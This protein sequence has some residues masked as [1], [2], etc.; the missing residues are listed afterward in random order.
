M[1]VFLKQHIQHHCSKLA[2]VGYNSHTLKGTRR[3]ME[4]REVPLRD[5]SHNVKFMLA[6]TQDVTERRQ[7]ELTLQTHREKL[8]HGSRVNM[9]GELAS[10]IAHELNQPLAAA[11]NFAFAL[12]ATAISDD[13][14]PELLAE[15][16]DAGSH[17]A[18][19]QLVERYAALVHKTC[20]R[21]VD[22]HILACR[23]STAMH[24]RGPS[25][26]RANCCR[27]GRQCPAVGQRREHMEDTARYS[28]RARLQHTLRSVQCI[29]PVCVQ[30]EWRLVRDAG[31]RKDMAADHGYD[32][33]QIRSGSRH[34]RL[35]R[36]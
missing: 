19:T 5:E 10:S 26:A 11:T 24:G 28:R 12:E 9:M 21:I 15:Y 32:D 8:A 3:H 1:G 4:S 30:M 25:N 23:Q 36:Q 2:G 35:L 13:P 18:F 27:E 17:D 29:L 31:Y 6:I 14:Q 7:T 33:V 22:T 16:A 20:R 34:A